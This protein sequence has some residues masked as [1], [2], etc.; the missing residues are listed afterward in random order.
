MREIKINIVTQM[1]TPSSQKPEAGIC[2]CSR[3]VKA[4][5][6][7][8]SQ[9]NKWAIRQERSNSHFECFS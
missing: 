1:C 3:E 7:P 9:N 6:Q 5:W 2:V 8:L 4:T